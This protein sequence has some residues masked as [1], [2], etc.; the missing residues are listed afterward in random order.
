MN[1]SKFR[2]IGMKTAVSHM[3]TFNKDNKEIAV[4]YP[5]YRCY[6]Q[7]NKRMGIHLFYFV[8]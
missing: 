2:K 5:S 6:R 8:S 7:S 1:Q 4:L 3:L